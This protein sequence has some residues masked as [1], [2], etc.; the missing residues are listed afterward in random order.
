[1]F[2]R[3]R[4]SRLGLNQEY[5]RRILR[6]I[7]RSNSGVTPITIF[8][9]PHPCGGSC[10]FCPTVPE[11]PKSYLPR[12]NVANKGLSYSSCEQIRYWL[13]Y[14]DN[15]GGVCNKI[16]VIILGGSF[17]AHTIDYIRYFIIKI[18]EA[19][20]GPL[21]SDANIEEFIERH[22][23]SNNNRVI[24]ITVEARP[25]HITED[26]VNEL[27]ALGVTKIEIGVQIISDVVLE[28]NNRG[29]G[30]DAI[31]N[32]TSIIK[33]SGLKVGYHLLFGMP[34]SSIDIDIKSTIEVVTDP[35]FQP[36]HVK[37]YFCEMFKREFMDRQLVSLYDNNKWAPYSDAERIKLINAIIPIIP[38]FIR[39]SR[40]GRK[41]SNQDLEFTRPQLIR[42]KYEKALGCKCIRCREPVNFVFKKELIENLVVHDISD[43]DIFIEISDCTTNSCFGI[44]RLRRL[45]SGKAVIRELH[46][47]GQETKLGEEGVFQHHG[48]GSK[49]LKIAEKTVKEKWNTNYL[50]VASGVGVRLYYA[51]HGFGLN[52][53][54]IMWKKI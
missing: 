6:T 40:I 43:K 51:R 25:D 7:M 34:G 5:I 48:V 45:K 39:I 16:E 26:V 13:S 21:H 35:S 24:G 17:L 41:A 3:I 1:M 52:E 27:F 44:L 11:I 49:L 22:Q 46:V 8:T 42:D 30:V 14:L 18:Y 54:N 9:K 31:K 38:R 15:R 53:D 19:I 10:I 28:F 20:D 23:F 36:D 47:Y 32:A 12:V 37:L 2:K 29:H 4:R 50:G 33:N